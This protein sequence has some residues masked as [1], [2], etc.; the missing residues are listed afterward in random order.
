MSRCT[1]HGARQ[2]KCCLTSRWCI[3]RTGSW[4][5]PTSRNYRRRIYH[6]L[7]GALNATSTS[8]HISPTNATCSLPRQRRRGC[9]SRATSPPSAVGGSLQRNWITRWL[10]SSWSR[11]NSL[12]ESSTIP[13]ISSCVA[14]Q[15]MRLS[16]QNPPPESLRN[17]CRYQW[18][19]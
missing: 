2:S 13:A 18:V 8:G 3:S 6:S 19:M 7:T 11:S 15:M 10:W 16:E 14:F 17:I 12:R 1:P 9:A 4:A 5:R